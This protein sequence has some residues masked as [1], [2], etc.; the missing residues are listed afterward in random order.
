MTGYE[1]IETASVDELRA[2]QLERMRASL[3]HAYANVGHYRSA[4]DDARGDPLGDV[5]SDAF[6]MY[7][8]PG[9]SA[10]WNPG[11]WWTMST[12]YLDN[13]YHFL[14]ENC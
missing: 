3:L 10:P 12:C 6:R 8:T 5:F 9:S 14:T 7:G 1:P 11:S 4:F 2:L 13:L